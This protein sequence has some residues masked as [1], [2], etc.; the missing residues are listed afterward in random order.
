MTNQFADHLVH[1]SPDEQPLLNLLASQQ[2]LLISGEDTN[3]EFALLEGDGQRGH[4][5]PRHLHRNA[6]E[7]FIVLEGE[8]LIDA[9]GALHEAPAGHVVLLPPRLPHSFLVVS[10]QARYLTM[11]TPAGF[12]AFVRDISDASRTSAPDRAVF[13]AIAAS[14]GIDIIGPGMRLDDHVLA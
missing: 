5:A 7:T 10:E 3:H 11:H 6:T 2:R 12:D 4:T 1:T 8:M 13:A 9:D 14:H